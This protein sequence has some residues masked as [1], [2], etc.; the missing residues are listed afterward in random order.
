MYSFLVRPK[1]IGFHLLVILG[2]VTMVNLGFW[3]LRRLDE[4]KAFNAEVEAR[5]DAPPMPLDEALASVD[6]LDEVEWQPVTASG[7]YDPD[8]QILI[9][10][11]SQ[12]GRAGDNVVV[13][14]LLD[15]GRVLLV[16]RGFVPLSVDVPP[17]PTGE[18]EVLGRLRT[19]QERRRGQLS[20]PAEGVLSAAQRV[21]IDRLAPQLP[22][23]VVPM[24]VDLIESDPPEMAGLPEQVTPPDLSEGPHLSYAVQWFLFS[25]AV[26]VGWVL[27]V[28]HSVRA[29]QH[30]A[31]RAAKAAAADATPAET[32]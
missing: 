18:V 13:P 15:D 27:A 32:G 29:R 6:D 24:Y 10:N 21:D 1:W 25:C 26:V 7:T 30:E 20:D 23:E 5:Y 19:S 28:R 22:G 12:N 8:G 11:R 4:R 14:L 3:Q 2:I 16:N 31:Q 9:V 17:A